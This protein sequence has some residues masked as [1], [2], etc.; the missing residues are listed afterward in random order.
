MTTQYVLQAA[1]WEQMAEANSV[2]RCAEQSSK[3][4]K[5]VSVKTKG[6]GGY[7][8]TAF[9]TMYGSWGGS[10]QPTVS[11][12]KLV[13][14]SVYDGETTVVYHDEDAVIA[15]LRKRS[16]HRG[17]IVRAQGR[18]MVCAEPVK[19]LCDLPEPQYAIDLATAKSH[20][21]KARQYGWRSIRCSRVEP[22]WYSLRGHP[23]NRY[24]HDGR[25]Y[26]S[27][28]WFYQGRIQDF[29]LDSDVELSSVDELYTTKASAP[30][31]RRAE[32]LGLFG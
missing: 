30:Q 28:L 8:Y 1:A 10:T 2:S 31:P 4:P 13:P 3:N 27:L 7:L 12:Y 19:F 9:A 6:F 26:Q 16:D 23:V 11:A 25:V 5:P 18:L 20:E 14:E 17:L 15:G 29:W 22:E 24:V 21:A 32:Q